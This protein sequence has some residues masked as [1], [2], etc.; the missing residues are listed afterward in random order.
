[1]SA[2]WRTSARTT[3][4]VILS[5]LEANKLLSPIFRIPW[6]HIGIFRIDWLHAAD[7]GVAAD[8]IGNVF[9]YLVKH[10]YTGKN[11]NIRLQKLSKDV[12]L[13]YEREEI[14]KS[15]RF[16]NLVFG[17]FLKKGSPPKLRCSAAKC[18]KLVK[19]VYEVT[20]LLPEKDAL[21]SQIKWGSY[22]LWRC[23]DSLSSTTEPS[24]RVLEEHSTKF[25]LC[26]VSLNKATE[27]PLWRV[28]PKIHMFLE[29]C[30]DGSSP[31]TNWC[32]RDEDFGGT[33]GQYSRRRGGLLSAKGLSFKIVRQWRCHPW[34][35]VR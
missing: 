14:H 16:D 19:F 11:K 8:W 17:L 24:A 4:D 9:N 26:F 5:I 12:K 21:S 27:D 32:Y 13:Y 35:R 23:Y 29:L 30:R 7:Q 15:D 2:S 22:H 34:K 20:Q 10:F 25:A 1:M 6:F 33:V 31:S 3:A 18:R 28:K